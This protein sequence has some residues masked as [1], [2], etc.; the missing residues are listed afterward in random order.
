[1]AKQK[2]SYSTPVLGTNK[3]S[4]EIK[5]LDNTKP[6]LNTPATAFATVKS[7]LIRENMKFKK[8]PNG[9][10]IHH[11]LPELKTPSV[12]SKDQ[13]LY[14]KFYVW[15]ANKK[16]HIILKDYDINQSKNK[17][18]F[19]AQRILELTNALNQGFH[20]DKIKAFEDQ[21]KQD[22]EN[23]LVSK[24]IPAIEEAIRAKKK[25][26]PKTIKNYE[27]HIGDFI[28][29]L[30][31]IGKGQMLCI[32]LNNSI[33]RKYFESIEYKEYSPRSYNN[34][35]SY[36]ITIWYDLQK[37]GYFRE[38]AKNP[39]SKIEKL[40][41]GIGKNIAY[42]PEQQEELLSYMREKY[43]QLRRLCLF[44]YYT[45]LRTNEI[46]QL[47]VKEIGTYR[48]GYIYLPKEKSKN[49]N[50][51]WVR[52]SPDLQ[53]I[54]DDLEL[55]KFPPEY[56]IFS[57]GFKPGEVWYDTR[58]FGDLYSKFVLKPLNYKLDTYSLYSWKHT[59][60]VAAKRAGVADADIMLQ[61]GWQDISSYNTYLKS[62]GLY[63]ET[64]YGDGVPSIIH[65]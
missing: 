59:G 2:K 7:F 11:I 50:A 35:R 63:A 26:R 53:Q 24:L 25:Y 16:K 57:K 1:M 46:S 58:K 54:I 32:H 13:R 21:E 20:L 15:D 64:K 42:R 61:A 14:I 17:E 8:A 19:A 49:N 55:H 36:L 39:F 37:A 23:K 60:V 12:N 33:I 9:V 65:L 5:G 3:K 38:E 56:F 52:I 51:R 48:E 43:P 62:L 47:Q 31:G 18:Q 45:L 6:F 28:E 27:Y 29:F 10:P 40:K 22:D 4:S 30:Y 44:M 34:F 41:T